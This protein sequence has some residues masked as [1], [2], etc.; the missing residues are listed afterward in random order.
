[1]LGRYQATQRGNCRDALVFGCLGQPADSPGHLAAHRFAIDGDAWRYKGD[2]ACGND[3]VL[4]CDCAAHIHTACR[5]MTAIDTHAQT[6]VG[7]LPFRQPLQ[8]A[9]VRLQEAVILL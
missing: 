8:Y 3:D 5:A 6:R 1:M 9:D 4:G 7:S 2:G